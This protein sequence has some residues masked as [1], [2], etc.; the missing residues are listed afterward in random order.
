M[1]NVRGA[2]AGGREGIR[3]GLLAF[4]AGGAGLLSRLQG[5]PGAWRGAQA[6]PAAPPLTPVSHKVCF[7]A[8]R[9]Y[10]HLSRG[11]CLVWLFN[12]LLPETQILIIPSSSSPTG[13]PRLHGGNK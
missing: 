13:C 12:W 10:F 4:A 9:L 7:S 3:T 2:W 1:S 8:A 6:A 5:P 11:V